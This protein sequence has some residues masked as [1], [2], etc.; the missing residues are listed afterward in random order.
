[1]LGLNTNSAMKDE[2]A[3][4]RID[5]L[6]NTMLQKFERVSET[7]FTT[8]CAAAYLGISVKTLYKLTGSN[9]KIAVCRPNGKKMTFLKSDLDNFLRRSRTATVDEMVTTYKQTQRV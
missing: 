7:T 3:H 6:C 2:S 5:E 8:E 4:R 9:P 1:M